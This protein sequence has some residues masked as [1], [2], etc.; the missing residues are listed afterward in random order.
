M[1]S[2]PATLVVIEYGASWPR[3]LSPAHSGD[4]AVVAQHYEGL[5][6]DLVAQVANRVTRLSQAHWQVDEVILVANGRSDPDATAA[7]SV[8]ARG[9]LA[10]LKSAGGCH[11]TLTVSEALGRR[12][13]HELTTLAAALE[14]VVL[15]SELSLSVRIGEEAPVYSR[16][17]PSRPA[18]SLRLRAAG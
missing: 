16:P 10:H 4:L 1:R 14:P 15:A 6:S 9:L 8:L 7:R 12:A 2:H 18:A 13:T 3:W 11:L 5:P 17:A